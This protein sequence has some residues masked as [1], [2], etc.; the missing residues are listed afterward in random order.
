MEQIQHFDRLTVNDPPNE[1]FVN[2]EQT[3]TATTTKAY[4]EVA[5]GTSQIQSNYDANELDR[6]ITFRDDSNNLNTT[7]YDRI[8]LSKVTIDNE[9]PDDRSNEENQSTSNVSDTT[10]TNGKYPQDSIAKYGLNQWSRYREDLPLYIR[11]QS[12]K[13]TGKRD[14][15]EC[16]IH[17]ENLPSPDPVINTSEEERLFYHGTS[18]SKAESIVKSGIKIT[19][20]PTDQAVG[21]AFYFND[22]HP[23]CYDWLYTNNSSYR[24]EHAML[25][26]KFN[27]WS[28]SNNG[29]EISEDEWKSI[30]QKRNSNKSTPD[31]SLTYQNAKPADHSAQGKNPIARKRSDGTFAKQLIIRDQKMCDK[32]NSCCIACVFYEKIDDCSSGSFTE[33]RTS[34]N[35]HAITNDERKQKRKKS[36]DR[37]K[38][39]DSKRFREE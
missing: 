16:N 28:F 12:R 36:K 2:E 7:Q 5:M 38:A 9:I 11:N 24:G 26:Y 8:A 10:V 14:I 31:W 3:N 23:D 32:I 34:Q 30:N 15:S 25:L 37:S 33:Q 18:W 13:K 35:N 27:P 20:R 17:L 21:G 4:T 19:D 6:L 29:E 1:T 39:R 22:S